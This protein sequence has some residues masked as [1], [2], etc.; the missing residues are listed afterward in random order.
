MKML[1][2]L[3]ATAIAVGLAVFS[4]RNPEVVHIDLLVGKVSVALSFALLGSGLLGALV[5]GFLVV[6][7]K[8]EGKRKNAS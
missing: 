8:G 1:A 3:I 4:A 6:L 2:L 5:G 7:L